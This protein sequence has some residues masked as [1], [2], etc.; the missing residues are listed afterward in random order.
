MASKYEYILA[1]LW[2]DGYHAAARLI[3][4]LTSGIE[5][6]AEMAAM[7]KFAGEESF[8][9]ELARDQLRSLWTAYC[10]HRELAPDTFEYD[11]DLQ[12]LWDAVAET[13]PE[14]TDWSD[15]DSFENFMCKYLV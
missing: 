12:E 11:C 3:E 15:F 14:T 5:P 6:E 1:P 4:K 2:R 7:K 10:I 13:E 8:E 9:D